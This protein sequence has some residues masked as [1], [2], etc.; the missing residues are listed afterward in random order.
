MLAAIAYVLLFL[1]LVIL[2]R[3]L[4]SRFAWRKA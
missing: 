3:W 2:A 4:E 1:P